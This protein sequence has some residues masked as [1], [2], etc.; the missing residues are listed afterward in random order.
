M[1][2]KKGVA[3]CI[4]HFAPAWF[5]VNMGTGAVSILF[6]AFPYGNETDALNAISAAFFVLNLILFFIFT[7]ISIMRYT[8]F[9]D[10]WSIMIRHPVQG[11]YLGTFPMGAATLI[12]VGTTVL[13]GQY[14]FGGRAF[15]YTLW[16][17]WW[18]DVGISVLCCWGVI[19]IMITE[20]H[21]SLHQMTSVW[22][23]PVVTLIV[24]SSA[25]GE[26]AQ[27]LHSYSVTSALTTVAFSIS[28]V[29]VGLVLAFMIL[30]IYLYRLILHGFPPGASIFSSFIPLGPMGQAGFSVLLIGQSLKSFLP[31]SG[32]RSSFLGSAQAGENVF[33][34]C[35]CISFFLWALAT[36]WL[37]YAL[38][39]IQRVLRRK[40]IPFK[41][42]FWGMTFPNGVYA[43]LTINLYR[44]LDVPFFRVWGAVYSV[45]TILLWT[46]VFC[47]TISLVRHGKIFEAPCLEVEEISEAD[48]EIN[49]SYP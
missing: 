10:V 33:A 26:L 28:M 18:V 32:S 34:L 22:L 42:S 6:A 20:Q 45:F 9:P 37:G 21:H 3:D 7:T 43:N 1:Y 36:M 23:L 44:V 38:L 17:L 31:V 47:R 24:A 19:Y 30:T 13:Y 2:T 46:A 11:L 15:L 4:R 40:R 27:A 8:L 49:S 5:A 35:V 39:G 25:G 41:L 12:G 48:N 14:G 16:G 29:S